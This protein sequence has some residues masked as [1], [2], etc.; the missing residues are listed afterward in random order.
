M[1]KLT[2]RGNTKPIVG[3]TE[4]Y[5]LSVFDNVMTSNSFSFP[6]PKVQWN[7]YVQDRNGWRI[8]N[9]NIKEGENVTY[10]FTAKSLKYKALRIE[11]VRGKI[12]ENS[13]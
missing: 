5:S 7:I 6:P 8:A 1:A 2:I 9:G 3:N 4:A 13:I 12:K 10:K 11:V